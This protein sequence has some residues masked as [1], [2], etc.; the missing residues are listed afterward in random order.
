MAICHVAYDMTI[1]L[2][3]VLYQC[4]FPASCIETSFFGLATAHQVKEKFSFGFKQTWLFFHLTLQEFLAAF[5]LS[6]LEPFEQMKLIEIHLGKPHLF[7][8]L[9]FFCGLATFLDVQRFWTVFYYSIFS[10]H[11][12]Y[13]YLQYVMHLNHSKPVYAKN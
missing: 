11:Q 8:T 3:R 12:D 5:Y 13:F 4:E 10:I 9:K 2:N 6:Q 7:N 1:K